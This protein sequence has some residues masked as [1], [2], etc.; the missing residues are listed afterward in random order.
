M[1][2][3]NKC[4]IGKP[5]EA[6]SKNR[7]AKDGHQSRCKACVAEHNKSPRGKAVQ[8]KAGAKY[9]KTPK[10][11][12]SQ[13]KWREKNPEY[14]AKYYAEN[15]ERIRE[16]SAKWREENKEWIREYNAK[17]WKENPE[18]AAK[19]HREN[20]IPS[21]D[22]AIKKLLSH[23]MYL[24]RFTQG[25][26]SYIKPGLTGR[27]IK[28]RFANDIKNGRMSNFE[29]LDSIT[30]KDFETCNVAESIIHDATLDSHVTPVIAFRGSVNECRQP[31]ALE[32]II[33]MF[34]SARA[35]MDNI[36]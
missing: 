36:N 12:A 24:I 4:K 29:V 30:F 20:F 18:Y 25:N 31:E 23:T 33:S 14:E 19:Y 34:D 27:T 7:S 28:E 9:S 11:K 17:W 5:F 22:W 8:A 2:T 21:P 13:A 32:Q 3:C 26:R 10:R 6:F 16:S 15:G 1:K 35:G